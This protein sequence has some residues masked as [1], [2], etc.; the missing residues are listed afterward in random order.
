MLVLATSACGSNDHDRLLKGW[1][2]GDREVPQSEFQTYPGPAHCD[3]GDA[4]ILNM[5]WPLDGGSTENAVVQFVRDPEGAMAEYTVESFI[6]D[7]ELPGDAVQTGY[8]NAGVEL[9]LAD[10]LS[11]AYL[12]DGDTVEAWPALQRWIC[13]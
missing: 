11:K 13:A 1:E 12:A 9:W 2:R 10:D 8:E 7:A 6:P 3:M 5:R 4:L